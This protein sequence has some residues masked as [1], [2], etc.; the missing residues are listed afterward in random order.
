MSAEIK[1]LEDKI[2]AETQAKLDAYEQATGRKVIDSIEDSVAAGNCMPGVLQWRARNVQGRT[3]VPA[4][5]MLQVL[6]QSRDHVRLACFGIL[7]AIEN[8]KAK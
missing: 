3:A 5:E 1:A 7:K 8:D 4:Q 2:I 6:R